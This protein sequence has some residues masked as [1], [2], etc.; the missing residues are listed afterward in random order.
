MTVKVTQPDINI[1]EKLRE[2]DRPVG[3][4]GQSLLSADTIQEQQ[5]MLGS[6]GRKN[7][8]INGNFDILQ[9]ASSITGPVSYFDTI[10]RWQS[11]SYG[12]NGT[13][14]SRQEL[15]IDNKLGDAPCQYH[16]RVE[17]TISHPYFRQTIERPWVYSGRK[18]T[19]SLWAKSSNLRK[20]NPGMVI[21]YSGGYTY[22]EESNI[23]SGRN[24]G[25]W[26]IS[27][28]W[29]K[30]TV[31]FDMPDLSG[32]TFNDSNFMAIEF[33][34]QQG[35]EGV[36]DIAQVQL[37]VGDVATPFEYRPPHEELKLCQRYYYVLTD[38]NL[39]YN[40]GLLAVKASYYEGIGIRHPV[41]MIKAPSVT[42]PNL[43]S[44]FRV[45]SGTPETPVN[46]SIVTDILDWYPRSNTTDN[47]NWYM[48]RIETPII[49]DAEF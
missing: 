4:A 18:L 21:F 11:Y 46:F 30:H 22:A 35:V 43:K 44:V 26:D 19:L 31:T 10:D 5:R 23:S 28:T 27:D 1:R 16:M 39:A 7:I 32:F 15:P 25:W 17:S 9:R 47:N 14:V 33:A 24:D 40:A 42:A 13:T 45:D 29:Q 3:Q 49:F 6:S 37:E 41:E 38:D 48:W 20:L 2:L 34:G 12:A 36:M 8:V